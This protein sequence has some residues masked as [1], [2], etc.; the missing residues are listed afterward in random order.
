M[1]KK[2]LKVFIICIVSFV[3]CGN[4]NA[5][6]ENTTLKDLKDK[7]AEYEKTYNK[8]QTDKAAV[9]KKIKEIEKELEEIA[10]E[11]DEDWDDDWDEDDE[12]GVEF[13]YKR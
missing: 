6:N 3:L 4:V 10:E 9:N 2:I 12:E 1:M 8:V 7:L 13:I 5:A 11:D